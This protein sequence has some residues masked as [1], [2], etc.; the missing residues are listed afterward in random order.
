MNETSATES[1]ILCM[2]KPTS[3]GGFSST[4]DWVTFLCS[5][6]EN[7]SFHSDSIPFHFVCSFCHQGYDAQYLIQKFCGRPRR[8]TLYLSEDF[9]TEYN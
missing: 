5:C 4:D 9:I 3:S 6:G 8:G 2:S 7:I 1:E